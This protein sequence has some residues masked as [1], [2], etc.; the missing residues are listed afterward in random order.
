MYIT[1]FEQLGNFELSHSRYPPPHF[2]KPSSRH[3][4]LLVYPPRGEA[5]FPIPRTARLI[6][7][8]QYSLKSFVLPL[9]SLSLSRV[10]M[11]NGLPTAAASRL[12]GT[13]HTA[14]ERTRK[15]EAAMRSCEDE[16]RG[17]AY[18][19]KRREMYVCLFLRGVVRRY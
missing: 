5:H 6:E 19:G 17:A 2:R 1:I 10:R 13:L 16:R 11:H 15:H 12:A 7:I 4:S 14:R 18:I 8:P 3:Y 9:L